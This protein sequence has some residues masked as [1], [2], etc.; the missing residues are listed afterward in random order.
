MKAFEQLLKHTST[1][2]A[3]WYVIPADKKWFTHVAVAD[4][5][6]AKLKS[7]KLSYPTV[8]D[9]HRQELLRA[10]EELEN[11]PS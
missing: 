9:E 3:P 6:V 11:E 10:K 8:S 1:K 5:I 7:M 4:L 2:W